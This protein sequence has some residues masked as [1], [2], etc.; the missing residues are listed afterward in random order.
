M[1]A[2][3]AACILSL[4]SEETSAVVEGGGVLGGEVDGGREVF[5]GLAPHAHV[6]ETPAP[7]QSGLCVARLLSDDLVQVENRRLVVSKQ[8]KKNDFIQNSSFQQ[9]ILKTQYFRFSPIE[10]LKTNYRFQIEN[11]YSRPWKILIAKPL[12]LEIRYFTAFISK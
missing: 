7:V 4:L 6:E 9:P 11:F 2:S 3:V 5:Q 10:H 8:I 1:K 12:I